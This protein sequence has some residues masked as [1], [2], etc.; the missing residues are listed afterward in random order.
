MEDVSNWH[1]LTVH[2][3]FE[4]FPEKCDEFEEHCNI[5]KN[6]FSSEDYF[7]YFAYNDLTTWDEMY[8]VINGMDIPVDNVKDF[9]I[10]SGR[11]YG[12]YTYN[13]KY[14]EEDDG[15]IIINNNDIL[16]EYENRNISIREKIYTFWNQEDYDIFN[17]M[18]KRNVDD[19]LGYLNDLKIT[20]TE[21]DDLW[22][23]MGKVIREIM[24]RI[25]VSIKEYPEQIGIK[26]RLARLDRSS[27]GKS[28]IGVDHSTMFITFDEGYNLDYSIIDRVRES[29]K[30][31]KEEKEKKKI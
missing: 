6:I 24:R 8:D 31:R 29:L 17:N 2:E 14:V 16:M 19:L 9:Y 26:A 4:K 18:M 5:L 30:K 11:L 23:I 12:G 21:D 25:I 7:P 20:Y 27:N 15:I 22:K 13:I 28:V 3:F 10:M 1:I